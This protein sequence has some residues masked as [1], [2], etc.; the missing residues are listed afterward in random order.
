MIKQTGLDILYRDG[1]AKG[2]KETRDPSYLPQQTQI[3]GRIPSW[4]KVEVDKAGFIAH[5]HIDHSGS[6][7]SQKLTQQTFGKLVMGLTSHIRATIRLG[8]V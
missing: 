3:W 7:G 1:I 8:S 5:F 6:I 4:F 2:F